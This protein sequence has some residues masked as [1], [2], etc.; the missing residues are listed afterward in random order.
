MQVITKDFIKSKRV[1]LRVDIDVPL[2]KGKVIED[3]R[4]KALLPTLR[5][6]LENASRVIMIGHIGR[7]QGKVVEEL[8]VSL[9]VD[10]LKSQGYERVLGSGK[11]KVLENLRFDRRE[12]S[13]DESFAKELALK[14]DVFVNEAF[15]AYHQA[16]STTVLPT[17]L[18]H[19]AGL[20]FAKEVKVLTG[21]RNNPK[22]PFVVIMGGVKVKDKLPVIEVLSKKADAV[23]IGGKLIH[24][25]KEQNVILSHNVMVGKLNEDGF[26]ISSD[27]TESWRNLIIGAA[28]IIWNGPMGKFEDP[29]NDQTK[30]VAEIVVESGAETIVGGGDIIAALNQAGLLNK[31]SFVS[32]GGGAMLKFLADGTLPTIKA[33][34]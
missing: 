6:C 18:P 31:I 19:A 2:E 28:Q 9:V 1:L 5:I 12:D 15:A 32:V 4:L 10:W 25:I 20:H 27:T 30:K 24:E 26:D 33:L 13:L 21:V 16:V 29:K 23:L 3:F 7:P 11:L 8:R 34:S 17:L 14:G 22:K